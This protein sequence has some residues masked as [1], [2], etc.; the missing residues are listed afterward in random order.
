VPTHFRSST[1]ARAV[2][3]HHAMLEEGMQILGEPMTP[4]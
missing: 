4:G 3:L 1:I 2:R